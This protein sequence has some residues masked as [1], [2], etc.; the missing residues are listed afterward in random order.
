LI[1][2]GFK[3]TVER[4][5][6]RC[7]SDE[8]YTHVGCDLV[9]AGYWKQCDRDIV[10]I[11]LKELDDEDYELKNDHIF[12]AHCYKGQSGSQQILNRFKRGGGKKSV[13]KH[14]ETNIDAFLEHATSKFGEIFI[15]M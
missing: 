15:L 12:F 2:N 10:V 8:E 7:F 11:G 6:F 3:I 13:L 14:I 9:D 1:E 4:S 5:S